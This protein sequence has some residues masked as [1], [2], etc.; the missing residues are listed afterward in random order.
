MSEVKSQKLAFWKTFNK[1]YFSVSILSGLT[2]LTNFGVPIIISLIF[3]PKYA[4]MVS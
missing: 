3:Y 2:K 4:K 1:I